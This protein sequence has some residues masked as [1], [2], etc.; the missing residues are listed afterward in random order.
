VASGYAKKGVLSS[1]QQ[2]SNKRNNL[3]LTVMPTYQVQA[4]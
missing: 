4:V 1:L 2:F 3:N